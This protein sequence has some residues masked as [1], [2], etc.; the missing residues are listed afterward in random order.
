MLVTEVADGA[1]AGFDPFGLP[2]LI[3]QIGVAPVG[4]QATAGHRDI[5]HPLLDARRQHLGNLGRLP[6]A[7]WNAQWW[8]PKAA[9]AKG[10]QPALHRA[11]GNEEHLRNLRGALTARGA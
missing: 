7:R 5:K 3:S 11:L 4:A 10:S 1:T 9:F 8:C 6:F 2:Q